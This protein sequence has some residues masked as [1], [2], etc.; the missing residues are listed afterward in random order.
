LA[1]RVGPAVFIGRYGQRL[2]LVNQLKGFE[3]KNSHEITRWGQFSG[4]KVRLKRLF[5]GLC[6]QKITLVNLKSLNTSLT[7]VNIS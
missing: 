2:A 1:E 3:T 5:W 4:A 6:P 7:P